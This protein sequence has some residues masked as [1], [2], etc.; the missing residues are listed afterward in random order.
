MTCNKEDF[1]WIGWFW[2]SNERTYH[3]EVRLDPD[4]WE[5]LKDDGIYPDK[6][7]KG[8]YLIAGGNKTDNYIA[9]NVEIFAFSH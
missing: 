4:H 6:D 1:I 2:I 9:K 7:E 8:W 5:N 3:D